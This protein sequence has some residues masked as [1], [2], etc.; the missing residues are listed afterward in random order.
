LSVE[1]LLKDGKQQTVLTLLSVDGKKLHESFFSGVF[2]H[3]VIKDIT[4]S[5][6]TQKEKI[7][8][9]AK[10][11]KMKDGVFTVIHSLED[12]E[13]FTRSKNYW[14]SE[15]TYKKD[16]IKTDFIDG[17]TL[18]LY[19]SNEGIKDPQY[20]RDKNL[21]PSYIAVVMDKE[22]SKMSKLGGA[23]RT[24]LDFAQSS[25]KTYVIQIGK[26]QSVLV[27]R[28]LDF[29]DETKEY[30]RVDN[31]PF[32]VKVQDVSCDESGCSLSGVSSTS[33]FVARFDKNGKAEGVKKYTKEKLYESDVKQKWAVA[34]SRTRDLV[35]GWTQSLNENSKTVEEKGEF[36]FITKPRDMNGLK[37]GGF[38]VV[39]KYNDLPCIELLDKDGKIRK[40]KTFQ[41]EYLN[42]HINTVKE[43]VNGNILVV[44]HLYEE[45]NYWKTFSA[46]LDAD[47]NPIWSRIYD[48]YDSMRDIELEEDGFLSVVSSSKIVKF[49]YTD[50]EVLKTYNIG[51]GLEQIAINS[52][53]RIV[54]IGV[55]E[56]GEKKNKT[57]S[58]LLYCLNSDRTRVQVVLSGGKKDKIS[59]ISSLGKNI[60]VSYE[61]GTDGSAYGNTIFAKV[62]ENCQIGKVK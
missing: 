35:T 54:G 37:K 13:E 21:N 32:K 3:L 56:K 23:N 12:V 18:V 31:N 33:A 60:F 39:G 50:G 24:V 8:V 51:K 47:A 9:N 20:S 7:I 53:G 42:G 4:L 11:Q 40:H 30:L 45:Y 41:F 61:Y 52:N 58:P 36:H 1:N 26:G 46:L 55:L 16:L 17:K 25:T 43:L 27:S 14:T 5:L 34:R 59:T 10:L 15:A 19:Q 6:V 62:D 57:V 29:E 48:D 28:S 38:A 22:T 49:S 2:K 44:G